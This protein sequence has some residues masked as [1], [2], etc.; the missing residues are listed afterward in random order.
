MTRPRH[1][2]AP[3]GSGRPRASRQLDQGREIAELRAKVEMQEEMLRRILDAVEG[4]ALQRRSV[5]QGRD[6]SRTS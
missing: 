4:P 5:P 2:P 1:T 3:S 6:G